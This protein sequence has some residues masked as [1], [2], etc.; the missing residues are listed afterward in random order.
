MFRLGTQKHE[1]LQNIETNIQ[2]VSQ[3]R[4]NYT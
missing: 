2:C 1:D 3:V 4:T